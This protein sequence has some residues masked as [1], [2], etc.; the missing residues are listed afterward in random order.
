MSDPQAWHQ[1]LPWRARL[2]VLI[3]PPGLVTLLIDTRVLLFEVSPSV[4]SARLNPH[5]QADGSISACQRLRS[6]GLYAACW[7]SVCK[8]AEVCLSLSTPHT[9][10]YVKRTVQPRPGVPEEWP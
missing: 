3:T 1:D 9:S 4:S 7:P 2:P 5:S 6:T 8:P 10:L